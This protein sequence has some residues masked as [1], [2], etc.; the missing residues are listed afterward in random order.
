MF[1]FDPQK[2][3]YDILWVPESATD[4][5]IK[6]AFRKWA[7]QHHPDKWGDQAKFQ[8]IN[9]AYQVLS[10][11]Q[12]KQ[13]YDAVR[14]WWYGGQWFGWFGGQWFWGFGDGATFQFWGDMW[15]IFGDLL[16]GFFGGWFGGWNRP[17]KWDDIELQLNISFEQAYEWL[18]KDISY[19]KVTEIDMQ[20]RKMKE[21]ND[22]VSIEVPAGIHSGQYLKYAGKWHVW[23]NGWP[24]GDLYIKIYIKP[25]NTYER[26]NDNIIVYTDVSIVDLVLWIEVNVSHPEGKIAVKIPKWTQVTDVVKVSWK[27]FTKISK[28][29]VFGSKHGDL[30]VKLRVSVPK[31]L[32]KEHEKLWKQLKWE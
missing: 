12:K 21:E 14:K 3:Y 11:G 31:K 9:E 16:W 17:R 24:A 2:N 30:L 25:S 1:D 27:W 6:K 13:Q 26:E 18:S 4:D 32:S 15:D 10:D 23:R 8:A 28:W 22:A 7:M 29:G 19:Q 20:T 5:E